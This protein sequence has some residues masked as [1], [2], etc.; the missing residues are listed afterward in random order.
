VKSLP[1]PVL[2]DDA[3]TKAYADAAAAGLSIL[4]PVR[5]ATTGSNITLSGG[6]PSTLDT[7]SL[8]PND[9]VLVKDQSTP[10]QNG[11]Y[12]VQTLGSGSNGTWVRTSDADVTGELVTGTYVFVDAGATNS[13]TSFVI[14]TTGTITI[15]VTPITWT[16]YF[17][18]GSISFSSITG[19]VVA[20]QIASVNAGSIVG[21]ISAGQIGSVSA[22]SI[23]G[24]ITA[25]QIGSVSAGTISGSITATQIG[26]VNATSITGVISAG[27]IGSVNAN[28]ISGLISS[29]QIGSVNAGVIQGAI[30]S[31][32]IS[33]VSAS[34][35][36][37]T[38]SSGQ[39]GSVSASAIVGLISSSQIGSVSAT[40]IVGGITA[41]QINN[42]SA[43]TIVGSISAGQIGSVSATSITG[44]IVG[45][46]L[47][48]QILNTQRLIASDISVVRRLSTLPSL[49]DAN[50]PVGALVL[51]TSN[52]TLYQNVSGTWTV[53]TSSSSVTGTLTANDIASVNANSIVG[54]II[55]NQI[56]TVSASSITGSISSSQIGSVSASA[57]TGTIT[58]SQIASVNATSLVGG[59]T[60]SQITSVSATSI[61][62]GISSSQISSV[63]ATSITGGITA[64]QITSVNGS[65]ITGSIAAN[66]ISG[67]IT[68]TQIT[69]VN[70]ATITG[71]ITATQ[72]G[73]VSAGSIAGTLNSSQIQSVNAATITVGTLVDSQIATVGAGK[74][75]SGTIAAQEI[76]LSNS[77]SSILRSDNY[78]AGTSGWRIR[79]NGDGE[80][81]NLT[82]RGLLAASQ[83]DHACLFIRPPTGNEG[84]Q[85]FLEMPTGVSGAWAIDVG[86]GND[87]RMFIEGN[88]SLAGAHEVQIAGDLRIDSDTYGGGNI[89]AEDITISGYG[90]G[91]FTTY[92]SRQFKENDA[93]ITGALDKVVQLV[94]VDFDW[95]SDSPFKAGKH[96]VGLIAEDV[97]KLFPQLVARDEQ[98]RPAV[99]YAKLSVYLLA[100]IKELNAKL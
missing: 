95:K 22:T 25:G 9:R 93:P 70:A 86:S 57:I 15:G 23:V 27:Q 92:S 72:I 35:I 2:P 30:N 47:T 90:Y 32:Q 62:G 55:A 52:Q 41:S 84:G 29:T 5:V 59:I 36:I 48:D 67:G 31:S 1:A 11:V 16:Q 12:E 64:T 45:A 4:S 83:I 88:P 17:S 20:G 53:V 44:V 65:A 99:N 40:T 58:A 43:T 96:D 33:S 77:L 37:G 34:S 24:T 69:S 89:Y 28:T 46:Q 85:V 39:I 54:L 50:Y 8:A 73:S 98:G 75:I 21:S 68:A 97:E 87:L 82:V 14:T 38:I 7:I 80:F 6:A 60:S 81:N 63:S 26:S 61:T 13:S 18:V 56:S 3:A 66:L 100:A 76:I 49:P 19:S 78:V 74:I 51:N 91:D 42:V 79:G 94:P 10:S 71:T